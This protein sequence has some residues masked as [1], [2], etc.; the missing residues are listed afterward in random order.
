MRNFKKIKNKKRFI[1]SVLVFLKGLVHKL[2]IVV[3]K[4]IKKIMVNKDDASVTKKV[5]FMKINSCFY[6]IFII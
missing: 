3:D 2:S 4:T 6:I 1:F 5:Y